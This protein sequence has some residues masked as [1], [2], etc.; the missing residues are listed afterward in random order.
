M[1]WERIYLREAQKDMKKL[2]GA[3][4]EM[5][6][7]L[8]RKVSENPLPAN[9][10]G[11]GK[12]LGNKG[13]NDLTGLLKMKLNKAGIRIVYTLIR[14]ETKMIVVVVG[15][16]ADDEVYEPAGKRAEK[17]GLTRRG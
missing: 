14:T 5:V 11:Y 2:G 4:R 8:V 6:I 12:P 13:G 16:R 17:Y 9:E 3:E 10:G 1:M 7:K 15:V